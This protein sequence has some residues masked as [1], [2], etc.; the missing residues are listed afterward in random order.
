[1]KRRKSSR[2]FKRC[3]FL[4]GA[5][6]LSL[7]AYWLLQ[8]PE[9]EGWRQGKERVAYLERGFPLG[10]GAC[11]EQAVA[12]ASIPLASA[13]EA[14]IT[15]SPQEP[16]QEGA[17]I[18]GSPQEPSQEE[19]GAAGT[20]QMPGQGEAGAAG[21][22]Q[23]PGQ[24]EAGAAGTPQMP[25][26]AE[27]R[28]MPAGTALPV[29]QVSQEILDSLFCSMELPEEVR[30]RVWGVSYQENDTVSLEEL[31]YLRVLHMG[32]DGQAHIG[33]LIVNQLIAEDIL[34]IMREL[35]RQSYPIEKM[36]LIDTYG[37]E[38]ALSMADNNTSAF[39]YREIAGSSR[40][41]KHAKGLA[42]DIN[43]LYN[44]YVK[45]EGDGQVTVSPP[46][47]AAYADRGGDFP[48]KIEGDGLC[49]QLFGEYGF[50]WGGS[51]NSVKDYQ[52]FEYAG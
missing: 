17:G 50:T 48:Y 9:G 20:P 49:C 25:N 45:Q 33:E 4:G 8:A 37:A 30:Q 18:T 29:S 35:Y 39:N 42:I 24:E 7:G 19:A 31:R 6:L 23:M 27:I 47:G 12:E 32:F 46:E 40:L 52:H 41:S 14:G 3:L 38:D 15:G 16:G 11:L 22:P 44:P 13:Q 1:M 34:A 51:W 28:E 5:A 2:F 36:L 10:L 43:P 21:T 26:L